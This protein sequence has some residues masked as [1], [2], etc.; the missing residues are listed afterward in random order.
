MINIGIE[1]Q[2]VLIREILHI[3]YVIA[4]IWRI[5]LSQKLYFKKLF[6]TANSVLIKLEICFAMIHVELLLEKI[7]NI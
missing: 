6:K 3:T 4:L 5:F 1:Y 7:L 2:N